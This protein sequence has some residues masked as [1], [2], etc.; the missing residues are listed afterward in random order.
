MKKTDNLIIGLDIGASK[1]CAVI[2]EIKANNKLK[3]Y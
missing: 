1:L 3:T 2:A